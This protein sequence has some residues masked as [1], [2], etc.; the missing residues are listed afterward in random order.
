MYRVLIIDDEEIVREGI[1]DLI[2]WEAE[3]FEICAEGRDGR[4]GLKKTLEF[5]PDLVL[6]DIKMP[7]LSGIELIRAAREEGFEGNFIIL[8]GY[9]EFD[10]AKSAIILGVKGYV[11]KPIDEDELLERVRQVREEIV[12]RETET[13]WN[14]GNEGKAREELLRRILLKLEDADKLEKEIRRY[15]L[16]S[17]LEH[18]TFCTAILADKEL[19]VGQEDSR[20]FERIEEFVEGLPGEIEKVMMENNAVLISRDMDYRLWAGQLELRNAHIA[21]KYGRGFLIC[22]G[23]NV[24]GWYDL[25]HS[26]EFASWLSE[27]AFLFGQYP[28]LS[29]EVIRKPQQAGENPSIDYFYMLMEIGD[30]DGIAD[31]V[32]NYRHYCQEH[33]IKEPDIKVQVMYNLMLLKN[34]ADQQGGGDKDGEQNMMLL[35]ERLMKAE[36]LDELLGIYREIL[37]DMCRRIGCDDSGTV[38]KR[39]YYYMEKNYA[40]NLKL[41]TIAKLFN[42]NS[43]YLGKIFRKEIGEN[44]NNVLDNIRITNAKRLLMETDLKVYQVSEQVGY[45][46]LDYFYMKFRKYVG[47]SPKEFRKNR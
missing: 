21:R 38:I 14:L 1:R 25:C 30:L 26:Y 10:Y 3:G 46:N 40:Q 17:F 34:R 23:H 7:G 24:S 18:H 11:L 8:T 42:Y 45:S 41:E 13:A 32:E 37:Q 9:S 39:M 19:M 4:D 44:F 6:V 2:D 28:S 12:S 27:N 33:L 43:T 35:M 36:E 31:C 16:D 15:R 29:M 5:E 47:M 22:V 20:F